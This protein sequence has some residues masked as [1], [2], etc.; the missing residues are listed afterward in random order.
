MKKTLRKILAAT[1]AVATI[2]SVASTAVSAYV[3][4][5]DS[6]RVAYHEGSPII[7]LQKM[8][9]TSTFT[10]EMLEG[11]ISNSS[12]AWNNSTTYPVYNRFTS[13]NGT[14]N[15]NVIAGKPQSLSDYYCIII[16]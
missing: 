13:G 6:D 10:R 9:T 12:N 3:W 1:I 14:G 7:R 4:Y 15:I 5:S 16:Y 2:S 8:W 11:L